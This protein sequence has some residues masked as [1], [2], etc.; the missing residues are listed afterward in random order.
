MMKIA[1]VTAFPQK[2]LFPHG[3]VEAVCVTL[4]T[5]LAKLN[6]IELH[7]V[8]VDRTAGDIEIEEWRGVTVHRLH[9]TH[10]RSLLAYATGK[11]RRQIHEYLKKLQPDII[12]A[13]DTYG[14]MV[15]GL[16]YPRIL[17]IHGFI[18]EDTLYA[19]GWV[20]RLRSKLWKHYELACWADHPH[21]I[22]IT[23]YVRERLRGLSHGM[24]HDIENPVSEECFQI[25]PQPRRGTIFSAAIINKRKNTVGLLKAFAQLLKNGAQ[26]ELRIAGSAA[27]PDYE[28]EVHEFINANALNEKVKLLGRIGA[29]QLRNELAQTSIFAL[30]SSEE[31]APMGIA[32]AMAAGVP[33]V[34]S[35]R[36]GIPYMVRDGETGFLVDPYNPMDIAW[37]LEQILNDDAL[38]IAL[39]KKANEIALE[40]FHPNHV[41]RRTHEVYLRLAGDKYHMKMAK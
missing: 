7:V 17:T 25:K 18:Y 10:G 6:D 31:G 15:T 2:P 28:R 3:G 37:R 32:E 24:I 16:D 33:V 21:I 1:F 23:P 19:G 27:E 29:E 40:R 5:A 36:C 39:G 30:V 8:T 38:R 34:A 35:N 12:H 26:A 9:T 20:S 14:L 41:A 22:S 13:H 4:A 11:G